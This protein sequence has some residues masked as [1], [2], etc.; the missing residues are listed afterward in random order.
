MGCQKKT[1]EISSVTTGHPLERQVDLVDKVNSVSG[2][3]VDGVYYDNSG[4]FSV[5]IPTDMNISSV[6]SYSGKHVRIENTLEQYAV[7]IWRIDGIQYKPSPREDCI[8]AFIDRATY[9][10]FGNRATNVGTCYPI[11]SGG[12]IVFVHLKYWQGYTW[13]LEAQVSPDFLVEGKQATEDFIASIVW[14]AKEDSKEVT[15]P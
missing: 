4:L 13:Q 11:A 14:Q 5:V 9:S 7:E 8:W 10:E 15:N 3:T 6:S 1:P 2:T 12:S